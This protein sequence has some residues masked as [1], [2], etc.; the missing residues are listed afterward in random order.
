MAV[1]KSIMG[2]NWQ[3]QLVAES[4][5]AYWAGWLEKHKEE[6]EK[7]FPSTLYYLV[8]RKQSIVSF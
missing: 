3:N 8:E 6:A 5:C 4:A 7:A 1:L 2:G